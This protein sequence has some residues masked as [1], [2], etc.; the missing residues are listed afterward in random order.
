MNINWVDYGAKL[1]APVISEEE[2]IRKIEY[3]Y[4]TCYNSKMSNNIED[5]I[6]FVK[7][8]MELGHGSPL[9]HAIIS[10]EVIIDRGILAEWTRHRIGSSYSVESTRYCKY[11]DSID[12]I[13][14]SQLRLQDDPDIIETFK[15]GI[16]NA[17]KAYSKLLE[18]NMSPQNARGVLPQSLKVK[19]CVTHNIREWFQVLDLRYWG[20]SGTPHPDFKYCM[21][22]VYKALQNQYPHI[23]S[24]P[25]LQD[26]EEIENKLNNLKK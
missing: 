3:C 7:S 13:I 23:F 20:K 6:K 2:I 19:M 22:K 8:K 12:C 5:S 1:L 25:Y 21:H 18:M 11:K 15:L 14:P 16:M 4:R 10:M 17:Y 24:A 9:E 26:Q